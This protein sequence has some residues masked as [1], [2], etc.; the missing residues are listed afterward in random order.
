ML[1][2]FKA[3]PLKKFAIGVDLGGTNLR[4]SAVSV[5]GEV[6]EDFQIPT[7]SEGGPDHI[8]ERIV[9]GVTEVNEGHSGSELIGVGIGVPGL[10]RLETGVIAK[11]PNLPGWENY[12]LKQRLEQALSLPVLVEND[13]NAAALGEVWL[14]AGH[15]VD[16]L[17]LLTLGTGIG[18]GIVSKGKILHGYL[19]MAGEIGHITVDPDSMHQC[20][21]GNNGC[22]ETE[23]SGTAIAK[24][25]MEAVQAGASPA[26]A[27]LLENEGQLTPLL[28]AQAADQGDKAARE[29]F[30]HMGWGLGIGLAGL[31]NTFNFPLYLLAGG[32]LAAWDLFSPAMMAEVK[33]RSVTYRNSETRI[34]KAKL[35]NKA[36]IY[37]AA[38]LPIQAH[39]ELK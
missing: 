10:I 39:Q 14:G 28:C 6:L 26:L 4:A 35:G 34:E 12:P 9:E 24:M 13:A 21:C 7:E 22:M 15:D 36:G 32:V 33:R 16:D 25:A 38:Y 1:P 5:D 37:G 17:V 27:A 23:S 31:I 8:V 18:G 30:E 20:G 29:I 3:G 19:G 2:I 11:A